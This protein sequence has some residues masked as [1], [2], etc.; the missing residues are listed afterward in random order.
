LGCGQSWHNNGG[1]MTWKFA[2]AQSKTTTTYPS[3]IDF[4]QVAAGYGG[5]FW[6]TH[7]IAAKNPGTSCIVPSQ[8]T[9]KVTG[10]WKPPATVS[11]RSTI[12]A[13]VPN[14]GAQAPDA[15]Y[16][17]V[18]TSGQAA[19]LVTINQDAGVDTWIDLGTFDLGTGAHVMLNNVT[20]QGGTGY[21][22]AWEAMA[23]VPA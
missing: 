7:T 5:H 23:F 15:V 21:D 17:V 11:G 9:L 12:W 4:H 6:F 18:T 16:Q 3:K 20:C 19:Q 2:A 8:P 1:T 22:I 14:V 10:I 13:A